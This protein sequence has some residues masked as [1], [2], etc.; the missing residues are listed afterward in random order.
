MGL[1]EKL[2][3][4][5]SNALSEVIEE[6][7]QDRVN[8]LVSAEVEKQLKETK[9]I[10]NIDIEMLVD[11]LRGV[12]GKIRDSSY[13]IVRAANEVDDIENNYVTD[14]EEMCDNIYNNLREIGSDLDEHA[15]ALGEM[16][17]NLKNEEGTYFLK[18]DTHKDFDDEITDEDLEDDEE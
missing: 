1:K 13:D 10:N 5:L 12:I 2:V 14:V 16:I 3:E 11:D 17:D 4:A 6:E 18:E 7:V 9:H 8:L 15:T